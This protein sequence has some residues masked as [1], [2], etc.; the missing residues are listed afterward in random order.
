MTIDTV[1]RE[2]DACPDGQAGNTAKKEYLDRLEKNIAN[3]K[4][5]SK[6]AYN[7]RLYAE[8]CELC[9]KASDIFGTYKKV[10]PSGF[11]NY[12]FRRSNFTKEEIFEAF[13]CAADS[14][15][16]GD[17]SMAFLMYSDERIENMRNGEAP[18]LS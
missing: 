9:E 7:K 14:E 1:T 6:R 10:T 3:G 4:A 5:A 2:S 18:S 16:C 15:E 13:E 17:F 12:C 8:F 11:R